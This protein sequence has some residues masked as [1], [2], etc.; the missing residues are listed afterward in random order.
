MV[1]GLWYC[2][3]DAIT[4]VK[5]GYADADTYKYE[6]M[7][8]LLARWEKIKKDKHGKYCHDKQN[9]KSVCSLSRLTGR[10]GSASRALSIESSHVREKGISLLQVRGWVNG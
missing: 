10:E 3:V 5:L 2:Q 6:P 8:V 4:D 1:R 9:K 7:T